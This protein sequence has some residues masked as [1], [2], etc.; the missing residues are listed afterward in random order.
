M[1]V[2]VYFADEGNNRLRKIAV[3]TGVITT[4]SGTG[5]TSYSGDNGPASSAEI[6]NPLGIDI[7]TA[8]R[9]LFCL[10][11]SLYPNFLIGF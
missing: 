9:V 10:P 7:D 2:N 1:V 8:G 4:V 6:Y 5:S 11:F 3:S